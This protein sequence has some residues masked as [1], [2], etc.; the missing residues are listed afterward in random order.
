MRALANAGATVAATG[1]DTLTV[2]G[3]ASGRIV[4]LLGESTVPF[5]EVAV[6]RSTLE[7]AY[8]ELTRDQVEF[9]AA[10]PEPGTHTVEAAP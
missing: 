8:M 4:D 2:T 6:H 1:P 5:S 9:R 3:L 10:Q 7:E